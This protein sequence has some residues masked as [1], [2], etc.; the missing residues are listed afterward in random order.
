[1]AK[2]TAILG[3]PG[4]GK[5]EISHER[6]RHNQNMILSDITQIWAHVRQVERDPDTNR[7]P[8]REDDEPVVRKRVL[9]Q[10][11]TAIVS[12][13]LRNEMDVI[14]TSGSPAMAQ[15]WSMVASDLGAEFEVETHDPGRAVVESRLAVDGVLSEQCER[16]IAR[17]YG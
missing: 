10:V 11:Q 13:G 17:W 15:R 12:I 1:M 6:I 4:S 16:A 3:P 7:Y 8:I 9:L 14:V 2:L 5:S